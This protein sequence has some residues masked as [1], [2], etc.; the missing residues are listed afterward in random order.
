M[1]GKVLCLKGKANVELSYW[2]I[3]E[4]LGRLPVLSPGRLRLRR[5]A[6]SGTGCAAVQWMWGGSF[7]SA[8][9]LQRTYPRHQRC[10]FLFPF[11]TWRRLACPSIIANR[12]RFSNLD[13]QIKQ[14]TRHCRVHSTSYDKESCFALP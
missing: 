8:G 2:T 10:P 12:K 6:G 5:Q 4:G 9:R 11:L 1:W 14:T 13:R 7:M 3:F